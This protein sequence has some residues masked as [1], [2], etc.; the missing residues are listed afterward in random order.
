MTPNV[1]RTENRSASPWTFI[2]WHSVRHRVG[3]QVAGCM[4]PIMYLDL[5][6]QIKVCRLPSPL[7]VP[8]TGITNQS[9]F[10]AVF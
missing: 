7:P 3:T 5:G 6:W 1:L 10:P 9:L 4:V 2:S 8:T